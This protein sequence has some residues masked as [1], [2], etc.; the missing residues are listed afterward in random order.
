VS[1]TAPLPSPWHDAVVERVAALTPR[2]VSV[3]LDVA[4]APGL[5]GQ[6]LVV[7]LTAPDG[8]AA[9]RSYSIASAPGAMPIE[10][11]VEKLED[12]EV[13]PFFHDV[14]AAGDSIEVRGPLGGH[15]V[16]RPAD[17]GPLLLVGGGSGVAP[18]MAM[19]R[20]WRDVG[21]AVPLLLV[22][23]ARMSDE[24]AFR[25]ELIALQARESLLRFVAV[26]TREPALRPGDLA[27]RLDSVAL[28]TLLADWGH[29]PALAFVC[30]TNRFV[31]AVA[32]GLLDA[33]VPAARIRTERYGGAD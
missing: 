29:V 24:L 3:F 2:I 33:A 31:E 17:G 14:V 7:R 23:S 8:Y 1:G 10:L 11:I 12:G 5:A 28:Q 21:A 32:G 26:T 22:V 13:S 16:W 4:L 18:L 27:R 20:A 15:F 30:G 9:Q 6:H 25:D 19:V